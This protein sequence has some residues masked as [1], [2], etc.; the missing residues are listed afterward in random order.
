MLGFANFV[1]NPELDQGYTDIKGVV[2][3][4]IAISFPVGVKATP[5]PSPA[6]SVLGFANFVP[7]PELDQG[8]A[9]ILG[10]IKCP[11]ATKYE[12]TTELTFLLNTLILFTRPPN[13]SNSDLLQ[14]QTN[15][16]L[17]HTKHMK[18]YLFCLRWMST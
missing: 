16:I 1:P 10:E 5:F 17:G 7:N 8:Y 18:Q 12:A 15:S 11:T 14:T 3:C 6:G 4:A 13:I 9:V 2:E